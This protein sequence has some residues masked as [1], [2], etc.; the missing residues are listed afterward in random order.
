MPEAPVAPQIHQALDIHGDFPAEIPFNLAGMINH[1]ANPGDFGV[2]EFGRLGA[3]FH[4]RFLEH[5]YRGAVPD[6]ENIG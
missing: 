6:T 2:G 4:L 5:P 1:L 3:G